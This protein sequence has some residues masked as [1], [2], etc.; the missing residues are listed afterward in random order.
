MDELIGILVSL[1]GKLLDLV[2]NDA[3]AALLV[4]DRV[5]AVDN[6]E[7]VSL[8]VGGIPEEFLALLIIEDECTKKNV[9]NV[10]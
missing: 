7:D 1:G 3:L 2:E 8:L 4:T 9:P 10:P 6:D 5:E